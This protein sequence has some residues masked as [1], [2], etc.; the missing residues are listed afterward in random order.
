[1]LR[2]PYSE[3]APLRP[4]REAN[5]IRARRALLAVCLCSLA[6]AAPPQERRGLTQSAK[7][8]RVLR[9]LAKKENA[10]L[11]ADLPATRELPEALPTFSGREA[12]ISLAKLLDRRWQ[13]V[14]G[15][16][17]FSRR[18]SL[19]T[20]SPQYDSLLLLKWVGSLEGDTLKKL[21]DGSL[22]G[23][24]IPD[25]ERADI[26]LSLP[27]PDN[28][29]SLLPG[30]LSNVRL[31]AYAT[32]AF[33]YSDPAT[34]RK[35]VESV[36]LG[37]PNVQELAPLAEARSPTPLA[38]PRSGPL[39]FGP[40]SVMTLEEIL[41][42]A[43]KAFGVTYAFDGRIAAS[44]Y[45]INGK[46]DRTT[47]ETALAIVTDLGRIE[48]AAAGEDLIQQELGAALSEMLTARARK[49][50]GTLMDRAM[51]RGNATAG[52]LISALPQLAA[53]FAR[54]K[55]DAATSIK[56]YPQIEVYGDLGGVGSNGWK[57]AVGI[58][59]R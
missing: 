4:A 43:E 46:L 33:E 7:L 21:T 56:L 25:S 53:S 16:Q 45:F 49:R 17:V 10:T 20:Q 50:L 9:A 52:E 8:E 48:A 2:L 51:S 26:L 57:N 12:M 54:K 24:E 5:V 31:M 40:G 22:T 36:P 35:I 11:F 19:T 47:F 55:L 1:M 39:D 18:P 29:R 32:I 27:W 15:M 23:A 37:E 38:S 41:K 42:R 28:V 58:A 13:E 14:E 30:R 59:I 3:I 6:L 34:G 44:K